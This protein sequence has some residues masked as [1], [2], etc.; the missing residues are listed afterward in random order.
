MPELNH[1][2]HSEE[3]QDILGHIPHWIIRWGISVLFGTFFMV[4]VGSYFFKYP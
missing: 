4:L 3:V 1:T 2:D